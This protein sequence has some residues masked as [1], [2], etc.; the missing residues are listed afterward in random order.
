MSSSVKICPYKAHEPIPEVAE[1]VLAKSRGRAATPTI[2][3]TAEMIVGSNKISGF[4]VKFFKWSIDVPKPTAREGPIF[5]VAMKV[6]TPKAIIC[7]AV[8]A[9]AAVAASPCNF[10]AKAIA[11]EEVGSDRARP[12]IAPITGA[13]K[14]AAQ[15]ALFAE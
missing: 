5:L 8:P 6:K 9:I 11:A 2:A 12:I 3:T 7:A 13:S 1:G 10:S 15:C 14:I 4:L